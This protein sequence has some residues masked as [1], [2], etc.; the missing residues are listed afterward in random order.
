MPI[1]S[2]FLGHR[3]SGLQESA[4]HNGIVGNCEFRPRPS[5]ITELFRWASPRLAACRRI[6]PKGK[7]GCRKPKPRQPALLMFNVM[8]PTSGLAIG[9]RRALEQ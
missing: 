4:N 8:G 9:W 1:S 6:G 7:D 3:Y 5:P 2:R